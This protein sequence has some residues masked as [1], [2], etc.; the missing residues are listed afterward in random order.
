MFDMTAKKPDAKPRGGRQP[1][2]GR[3]AQD[4]AKPTKMMQ[5]RLEP[6]QHAKVKR[7]GGSVWVRKQINEAKEPVNG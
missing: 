3:K 7:L 5:I 2:A 4:G 6:E 1:G